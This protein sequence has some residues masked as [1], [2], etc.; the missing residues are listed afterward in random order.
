M[1]KYSRLLTTLFLTLATPLTLAAGG[2]V[3]DPAGV[4]PDRY[5]YYPG[6]EALNKKE[7]REA[8]APH[9]KSDFKLYEKA[10]ELA[11]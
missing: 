10:L 3:K 2:V 6:T 7:I 11:P 4:A 9:V 5:V 8:L 1:H